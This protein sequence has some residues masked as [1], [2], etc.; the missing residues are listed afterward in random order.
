MHRETRIASLA[1]KLAGLM[2]EVRTVFRPALGIHVSRRTVSDDGVSE[3]AVLAGSCKVLCSE[4]VTKFYLDSPTVAGRLRFNCW[5]RRACVAG[6]VFPN[7]GGKL[8]Y[9]YERKKIS[10]RCIIF[11]RAGAELVF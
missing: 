5:F 7:R 2:R 11:L 10:Y 1:E 6:R 3:R 8:K 4:A 9:G